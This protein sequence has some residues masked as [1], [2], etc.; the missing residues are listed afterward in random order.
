VDADRKAFPPGDDVAFSTARRQAGCSAE[1]ARA[2]G[3]PAESSSAN[4]EK[5]ARRARRGDAPT[6]C[7][8][9]AHLDLS[10]ASDVAQRF[11]A[12]ALFLKRRACC[13]ARGPPETLFEQS[14]G[15]IHLQIR[16]AR[17]APG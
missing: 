16:V 13:A 10:E 2:V 15:V 11:F 14:T 3:A 7:M 17:A 8:D 9:D 4:E 12:R 5:E 1:L 6:A